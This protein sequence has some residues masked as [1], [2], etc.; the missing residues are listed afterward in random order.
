M[1]AEVWADG[2]VSAP[3]AEKLLEMNRSVD[4]S[5][6]WTNFFVEAISEFMLSQGEPR[7]YVTEDEATWLIRHVSQDGRVQTAAELELIVKLLE[8]ADYAPASLRRFALSAIEKRCLPAKVRR[9]VSEGVPGR[10]DDAEVAT[11]PPPHFRACR[12]RPGQGQRRRS[13]DAIPA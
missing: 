8:H 4:P 6:E 13:R 1:R 3:E 10:I 2:S 5:A 12:R 9:D 7:G 11:D